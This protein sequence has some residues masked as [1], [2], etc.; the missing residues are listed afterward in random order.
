MT[1]TCNRCSKECSMF[2]AAYKASPELGE[3]KIHDFLVRKQRKDHCADN[4]TCLP[5]AEI[6]KDSN[7]SI[8]DKFWELQDRNLL[9]S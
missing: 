7:M 9:G 2:R 6:R 8:A 3:Q 5:E 1:Q 4:V